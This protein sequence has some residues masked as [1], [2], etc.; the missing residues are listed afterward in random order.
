M[1]S[2]SSHFTFKQRN[3]DPSTRQSRLR[4]RNS[5]EPDT[6]ERNVQGLVQGILKEDEEKRGE[7]LDLFNIQPKRANW[8]LKRDM[9][10]RMAKMERRT[11]E[12]IAGIFRA[13]TTRWPARQISVEV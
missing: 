2:R 6:V 4:D 8:D 9:G 12:A 13:L 1:T 11:N 5:L 3:F 10:N 7:D